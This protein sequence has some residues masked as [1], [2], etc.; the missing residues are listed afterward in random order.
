MLDCHK[1]G[2]VCYRVIVMSLP[3]LR[4]VHAARPAGLWPQAG[5]VP[6]LPG[7][8][9]DELCQRGGVQLPVHDRPQGVTGET[10]HGAAA[11]L[12]KL[13][14][15]CTRDLQ[16][17]VL[18]LALA[19]RLIMCSTE[20]EVLLSRAGFNGQTEHCLAQVVKE[21]GKQRMYVGC[22]TLT[23]WGPP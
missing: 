3:V 18:I 19:G 17:P 20:P 22:P 2:D 23:G 12:H 15:V 4:C 7:A 11:S 1:L 21:G 16:N 6:L 13:N 9:H 8:P 10:Q 14:C 5:L